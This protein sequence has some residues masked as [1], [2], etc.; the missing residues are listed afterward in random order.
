MNDEIIHYFKYEDP[1]VKTESKDHISYAY[2][3]RFPDPVYPADSSNV[4]FELI[5]NMGLDTFFVKSK[6]Y[7]DEIEIYD[8][9]FFDNTKDL[10]VFWGRHTNSK[11]DSVQ[12]YVI[13]QIPNTDSIIFRKVN[14]YVDLIDVM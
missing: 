2:S 5:Y 14:R 10:N 11:F 8:A 1:L 9:S 7:V 4:T 6:L 12:I 13:E 3:Y